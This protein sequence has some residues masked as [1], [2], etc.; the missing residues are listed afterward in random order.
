M[1]KLSNV[2]KGFDDHH[3]ELENEQA[4]HVVN[5]TPM[6][7]F[8]ER[9]PNRYYN[10]MSARLL[11]EDR[12]VTILVVEQIIYFFAK[13][14]TSVVVE[15]ATKSEFGEKFVIRAASRCTGLVVRRIR[16]ERTG[17]VAAVVRLHWIE[18]GRVGRVHDFRYVR[19]PQLSNA[20]TEVDARQERMLF[21]LVGILAQPLL[22]TGAQLEDE[23]GRF[24]RDVRVGRN[25]Q[26]TAPVDDLRNVNKRKSN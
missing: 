15:E 19:R 7:T 5:V 9:L 20:S 17:F 10:I 16:L 14:D 6:N 11:H 4:N 23:V 22:G 25:F 26:R 24:G 8:S 21:D 3:G 1:H 12:V 18:V 2:L 13:R